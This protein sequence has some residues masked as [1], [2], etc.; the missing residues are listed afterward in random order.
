MGNGENTATVEPFMKLKV[1]YMQVYVTLVALKR[2]NQFF[3]I[4]HGMVYL[5]LHCH[6]RIW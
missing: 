6:A 5:M 2:E 4:L 3:F 1:S